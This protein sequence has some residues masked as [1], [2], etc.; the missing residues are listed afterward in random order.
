MLLPLL[1]RLPPLPLAMMV[2]VVL[3]LL[4]VVVVMVLFALTRGWPAA[5]KCDE[6]H[7]EPDERALVE[8]HA[9]LLVT[10]CQFCAESLTSATKI[11]TL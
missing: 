11:K 10:S 7:C 8:M 9:C 2:V 6:R 4:L 5:S 1:S 3:L